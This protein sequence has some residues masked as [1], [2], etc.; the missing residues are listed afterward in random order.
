MSRDVIFTK[1]FT[2][3]YCFNHSERTQQTTDRQTRLPW[4]QKKWKLLWC[5]KWSWWSK[6]NIQRH[7]LS[8][9]LTVGPT[10][11]VIEKRLLLKGVARAGLW[12]RV[13]VM[14][15]C[16]PIPRLRFAQYMSSGRSASCCVPSVC[17]STARQWVIHAWTYSLNTRACFDLPASSLVTEASRAVSSETSARVQIV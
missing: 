6:D 16:R 4:Q 8:V 1:T 3:V 7:F 11:V 15:L 13:M 10:A 17:L 2:Y 5:A 12:A 9:Q 14:G